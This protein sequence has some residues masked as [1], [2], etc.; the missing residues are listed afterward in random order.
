MKRITIK[1]VAKKA[2]VSISAVS[3]ILNDS[4]KKKYSQ[5]TVQRVKQAA[6]ELG[7]VP[8]NIARS[9][10][11]Q[12]THAIG[13][14]TRWSMG[15]R[16]FVKLLEG[17]VNRASQE[18]YAVTICPYGSYIEYFNN[19]RLDGILFIAS[20]GGYTAEEENDIQRIHEAGLPCVVINGNTHVP[21]VD[22]LYFD[23]YNA[24]EILTEYLIDQGHRQI[25]YV[26][27]HVGEGAE[28][29]ERLRGYQETMDRHHLPQDICYDTEIDVR[30]P[31]FKA[32]VT[33]KSETARKVLEIAIAQGRH[34][35]QEFPVVAGNTENYSEFLYPALTTTQFPFEQIGWRAVE[36]LLSQIRGDHEVTIEYAKSD[37][38]RHQ[39]G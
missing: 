34:I 4:D 9:M 19:C 37:I 6:Q 14:V 24:V 18:N 28:K 1:D 5:E 38:I 13:V 11:S 20:P 15:E 3:Y 39:S 23:Y 17:I 36:L 26:T 32:V 16:V 30:M 10:R 25:T 21:D 35:P 8:N 29:R 22:Y 7:Y 27:P 33:H 31:D 2:G 12:R